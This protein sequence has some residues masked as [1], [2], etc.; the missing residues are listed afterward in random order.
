MSFQ[1]LLYVVTVFFFP[2]MCSSHSFEC[3]SVGRIKQVTVSINFPVSLVSLKKG[4]LITYLG[5]LSE[6]KRLGG[7]QPDSDKLKYKLLFS[8]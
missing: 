2:L 8:Q 3:P 4:I 7:K 5:K 6:A 1:H